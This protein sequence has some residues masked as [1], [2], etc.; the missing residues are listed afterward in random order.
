MTIV[1]VFTSRLEVEA[2]VARCVHSSVNKPG[3]DARVGLGSETL[4]HSRL[5]SIDREKNRS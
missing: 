5:Y 4:T 2:N 3:A 1:V